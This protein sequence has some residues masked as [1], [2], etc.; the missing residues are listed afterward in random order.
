ML[1]IVFYTI[2]VLLSLFVLFFMLFNIKTKDG[3]NIPEE[4][5]TINSE[6]RD[7]KYIIMHHTALSLEDTLKVFSSK[8]SNVS[9][10]YLVAKDGQ[11]IQLLPE[12]VTAYHAGRSY[13]NGNINLNDIS[14]GIEVV[15]LGDEPFTKEQMQSLE[16]LS[17]DIMQRYELAPQDVLAH[18]DVAPTRKSDP[19]KYFDW[20]GLAE[21]NIGL[22]PDNNI[23]ENIRSSGDIDISVGNVQDLLSR[24]G[25]PVARNGQMDEVTVKAIEA[26][27]LRYRPSNIS[28]SID[29]ETV[30]ILTALVL[31][32]SN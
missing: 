30:E 22:W 25:Y 10:H 24:L 5:Y 6:D 15:N 8:R 32:N 9:A 21:K 3:L 7:I 19:N 27:Q 1:K 17:L 26:F 13:W 23:I 29:N 31:M 28:G 4:N 11:V 14:I 12:N 16:E 18:A 2:A 20:E